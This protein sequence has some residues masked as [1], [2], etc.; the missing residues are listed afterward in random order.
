MQRHRPCVIQ[1]PLAI[2]SR[3]NRRRQIIRYIKA[4]DR[5]LWPVPEVLALSALDI[6]RPYWLGGRLPF[7][8]LDAGQRIG[9]DAVAPGV[10]NTGVSMYKLQMVVTCSANAGSANKLRDKFG[11]PC[12]RQLW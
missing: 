2:S 1:L 4:D 8:G 9:T 10:C 6:A 7:E 12:S 5:W 11:T 3:T